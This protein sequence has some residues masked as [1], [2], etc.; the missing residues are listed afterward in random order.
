LRGTPAKMN[1]VGVI[2]ESLIKEIVYWVCIPQSN[3]L[4]KTLKH[5]KYKL[6][7]QIAAPNLDCD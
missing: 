3:I 4:S 1:D 2:K 7:K 5:V 6:P